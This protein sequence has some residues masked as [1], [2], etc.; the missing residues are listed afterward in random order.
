MQAEV[1]LKERRIALT[2]LRHD[3][4]QSY[5]E[6][7]TF[8]PV[9]AL[10]RSLMFYA[11]GKSGTLSVESTSQAIRNHALGQMLD[12]FDTAKG[13]LLGL[14]TDPAK[15]LAIAR[16]L[17]GTKTCDADAAKAAKAFSEVAAQLRDRFNRAGGNPAAGCNRRR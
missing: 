16:E 12:V 9:D 1:A 14:V 5:L 17:R 10:A 8:S 2:A 15:T 13:G 3:A 4:V 11:D 6:K 7:S